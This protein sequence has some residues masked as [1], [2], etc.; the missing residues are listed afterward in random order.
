MSEILTPVVYQ[1]GLGG[2]GGFIVGYAIKKIVKIC[3]PLIR[4][5]FF[6]Y[7]HAFVI[8]RKFQYTG[9]GDKNHFLNMLRKFYCIKSGNIAPIGMADKDYLFYLQ[10]LSNAFNVGKLLLHT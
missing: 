2:I 9:G 7:S 10:D 8:Y 6:Y 3:L 5:V 4:K 1:L